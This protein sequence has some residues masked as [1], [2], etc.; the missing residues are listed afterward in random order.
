MIVWAARAAFLD[1]NRSAMADFMADALRARRFYLNPADHREA[2][3]LVAKVAHLPPER[4]KAWLFTKDDYYRDPDA[5][6]DLDALQANIDLQR[7]LGFLKSGF[8][9]RKF[10]DLGFAQEAVT[11]LK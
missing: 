1:E 11:R 10:A 2:V 7:Q 3:E 9:V 6:P 5:L 8:D 4:L